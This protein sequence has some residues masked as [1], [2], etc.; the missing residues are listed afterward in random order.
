MLKQ[1]MNVVRKVAEEQVL[2]YY[3]NVARHHKADG[4]IFTTAD[5][6]A[7]EALTNELMSLHDCPVL[8]EEMTLEEQERLWHDHP[9]GLWVVDPIDG[10]SNF[11]NGLPYFAVSVALMRQ[12]RSVLA[13]VYSPIDYE[14]FSAEV[15]KGAFLNGERLPIKQAAPKE[16][17]QAMA[18]IDFKRLSGP[19][20]R[21]LVDEQ[22]YS[23]QR[24]YGASTLD[25]CY[26]AAGRFDVYLHGGQK[27][28]DYAAGSLILQEAGGRLCTLEEDD[29][30]RA[31]VW[32]R[33]VIAG[34]D[35]Q[36][37]AHWRDWLRQT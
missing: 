13:C 5:L 16:L 12:G 7:Q 26:A 17:H 28:W 21:R 23:S 19:L 14:M 2:P 20:V 27:L 4:S 11:V 3:L 36:L 30:W 15:G 1:V 10:T 25:W 8:G 6:A 9:D 31:P 29:F 18:G 22:P 32:K 35:P 24:N 33:S 34:L 37:F